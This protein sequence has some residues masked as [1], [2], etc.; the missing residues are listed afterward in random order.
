VSEAKNI[1]ELLEPYNP[2]WMNNEWDQKDPLL[3]AFENSI[4]KDK[5]RLYYHIRNNITKPDIYGIITIRGPRR[6]GKTTMI[7]LLIRHLIKEKGINPASI[8]YISLDYQGLRNVKLSDLLIAIARTSSYEKYI[9]L[10]EASM[11][12]E[13]AQ[14]LKNLYDAGLIDAYR[15]KIIATGSHSM[16]LAEAASKLRGRQGTLAQYFNVSGN[17]TYVPLRFPEVAE[18][19]RKEISELFSRYKLRIPGTRFNL[20]IELSTG[21]IPPIIQEIYNNYFQLLQVLWEDY[22]IHG[23]YPQA[24]DEYYQTGRISAN[25]YSDLA[26]LLVKDS[27]K[28]NLN[29]ENLKRILEALT[30]SKRLSSILNFGDLEVVGVNE[31]ARPKAKFGLRAYI[32][33]LKTTW[34]FFFSYREEGKS[35]ECNPNLQEKVKNYVLDPFIYHA[36]YSYLRNIPDPFDTSK[37]LVDDEGFKGQLIESVVASHVLLSQQ[38]FERV[39]SIDYT[40]VLMYKMTPYGSSE[41]ETDFVLCIR[42]GGQNYRFIIESKYRKNPFHV[43]PE[44]GK[45]VLTK[46]MLTV[47]NDMVYIPVSVFLLIF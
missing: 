45:I 10:D 13:W 37:K 9:F 26:E 43:I 15:M 27:E 46:E 3:R 1:Q 42:R 8:F 31:D 33:Y 5:P 40:K 17:L 6:V 34:S 44:K 32:E 18:A 41:K 22:L 39:P 16:D 30:E 21:K 14:A 7:K 23:G 19:I 29:P 36:L 20:L 4:L 47:K 35:G 2:W 38:L 28:A 11:Y 24:I 12:P 25:F